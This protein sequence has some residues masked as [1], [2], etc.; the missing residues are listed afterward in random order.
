MF[1]TVS[2]QDFAG[3]ELNWPEQHIASDWSR[4]CEA[5]DQSPNFRSNYEA[6]EPWDQYQNFLQCNWWVKSYAVFLSLSA[7]CSALK[8]VI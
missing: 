4:C 3:L 7:K 5:P 8:I 2:L 6:A 1:L